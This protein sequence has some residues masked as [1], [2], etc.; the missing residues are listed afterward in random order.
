VYEN[1]GAHKIVSGEKRGLLHQAAGIGAK[2]TGFAE[3]KAAPDRRTPRCCAHRSTT[4]RGPH[5]WASLRKDVKN[6][7][8]SG[9]VYENT[10][11]RF[12]K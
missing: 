3:A 10:G 6:E 7:G 11:A 9:D 4:D 1:T 8:A 12:A 5:V 2:F